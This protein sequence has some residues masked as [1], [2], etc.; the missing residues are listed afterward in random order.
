MSTSP[1]VAVL[2]LTYNHEKFILDCL[3][4]LD[5]IN[6]PDTK[7]W[8][9]DDGSTDNTAQV[10]TEFIKNKPNYSFISQPNTGNVSQNTQK[11]FD[12]STGEFVIFLSADDYLQNSYPV[13]KFIEEFV[14]DSSLGLI[15]PNSRSANDIGSAS[16]LISAKLQK[17]LSSGNPKV[18]LDKHLY[19]RVSR[20]FMQGIFI[21]RETVAELGGF[22]GDKAADDYEFIFSLFLHLQNKKFKFKFFDDVFWFY[23]MHEN[24]LHR[25]SL[26]Q[27]NLM[28]NTA[29]QFVPIRKRLLF[30]WDVNIFSNPQD[31]LLALEVAK[32]QLDIFSY[33]S[34]GLQTSLLSLHSAR[35]RK[36]H[37]FAQAIL[38]DAK[39]PWFLMPGAWLLSK[40]VGKSIAE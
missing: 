26:R 25:V 29:K 40:I 10:V 4:S 7:F 34:L 35:I 8:I 28:V 5:S 24:N 30:R 13:A 36:D 37:F 16:S 27:F 22:S 2:V 31:L 6:N 1:S 38:S 19:K 33:Y 12:V 32:K 39:A 11:L 17:I 14:N 18:V 3:R 20:I 21:K 9:L 23:R 15:I